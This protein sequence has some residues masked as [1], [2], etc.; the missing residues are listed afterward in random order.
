MTQV[1]AEMH[2]IFKTTEIKPVNHNAIT[3][4]AY[5]TEVVDLQRIV[6]D[7][8]GEQTT[9]YLI[10]RYFPICNSPNDLAKLQQVN[11]LC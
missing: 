3:L 8:V 9:A 4:S 10:K 11:A 1:M 7:T 6:Y 5:Y 2:E